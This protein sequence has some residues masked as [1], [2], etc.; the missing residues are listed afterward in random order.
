[1]GKSL[2]FSATNNDILSWG[3][4]PEEVFAS[5]GETERYSI[6]GCPT[7][8]L[9]LIAL[10]SQLKSRSRAST[11]TPPAL[12]A[13]PHDYS[14]LISRITSFSPQKWIQSVLPS[15]NYDDPNGGSAI[16]PPF[17]I[18]ELHHHVSAYKSAVHIFALQVL[19]CPTPDATAHDALVDDL[20]FTH[21]AKIQPGSVFLKG[22]VWPVFVAGAAATTP[23][24][25]AFVKKALDEVWRVLPQDNVRS[26][27][28]LL[29]T[30][31]NDDRGGGWVEGIARAGGDYLF[32]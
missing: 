23:R 2:A 15:L 28:A 3:E 32:I 25:R 1:M 21:I 20:L 12:P 31:W 24:Q 10:V 6:L 5:L 22:A 16:P 7:E 29:E 30:M 13:P 18:S 9:Q 17:D 8:L 4:P 27:A 19:S 26:A 14:L 11:S